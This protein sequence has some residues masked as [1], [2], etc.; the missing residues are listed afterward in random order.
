MIYFDNAATS[1]VK[2]ICVQ[3]AMSN[4][5]RTFS[6]P[7]RGAYSQAMKAAEMIYDCRCEIAELFNVKEIENIIFTS[8]ASHALN[9]AINSVVKTGARILVSG[10]EHNSV[11]R[12]IIAHGAE[13]IVAGTKLF[14]DNQLLNEFNDKIKFADAVVCTH[15]SNVF[16]Y[17]L[18][19]YEIA[20]LCQ[21]YNKP[22]IVD[23][24]QSAGILNVDFEKLSVAFVAMPG[25]KALL[26][27]QGTGILLCN[28]EAIPLIHGGSGSES[29]SQH[30]PEFLP[31]RLEAGTHN[32]PGIAGLKAGVEFVRDK[33][34]EEIRS[35]ETGLLKLMIKQME[36]SDYELF[37]GDNQ[38]GVLSLRHSNIDSEELAAA[39]SKEDICIR[40][41]MHCSPRAHKS[42]GTYESGT[43]RFSFSI[44]NNS[45]E[46][47]SAC[48]FLKNLKN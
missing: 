43:A 45:D 25:H 14:D 26:G 18:P 20:E 6:S 30:M 28:Y 34:L 4:A 21:K 35:H 37:Y 7:G 5:I 15:V 44:F 9:I 38:L 33:G 16:G 40:A 8:S 39:L 27:P 17:I 2:P 48:D 22:L 23:A 1:F 24:S 36:N 32:V 29:K 10:F 19:I 13:I 47:Y 31:D 12:P 3:Y 11:I 42:A 41:G 46:I